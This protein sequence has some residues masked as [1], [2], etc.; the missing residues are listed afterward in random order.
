MGLGCI[1]MMKRAMCKGACY[2]AI[3]QYLNI[4]NRNKTKQEFKKHKKS[5]QDRHT[6]LSMKDYTQNAAFKATTMLTVTDWQDH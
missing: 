2:C 4:L 3:Q 5:L 6:N 1:I